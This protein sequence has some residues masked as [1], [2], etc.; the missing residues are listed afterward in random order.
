MGSAGI[1]QILDL[2]FAIP[3]AEAVGAES[4]VSGQNGQVL[5]LVVAVVAAVG[6][7]VAYQRAVTKEEEVRVR[8]EQGAAGVAAEAVDV[9]SVAGC[10]DV[11]GG[12]RAEWKAR[13]RRRVPVAGCSA[14]LVRMP[15]LPRESAWAIS[16]VFRR[17]IN[18][19]VYL[20]APLARIHDIVLVQRR[21][22]ISAW[23]LHRALGC[24]GAL[25]YA[26]AADRR[27]ADGGSLWA[28]ASGGGG[29]GGGGCCS[30]GSFFFGDSALGVSLAVGREEG[31]GVVGRKGLSPFACC[32]RVRRNR[33]PRFKWLCATSFPQGRGG[34]QQQSAAVTPAL[35]LTL[36]LADWQ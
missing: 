28:G 30:V 13:A 36:T 2:A 21:L 11:S 6:A 18:L 9:P 20:S 27:G 8:V 24:S 34:R 23:R 17:A 15:C 1:A 3:A 33:G 29:S 4:L 12:C 14:Y 5:D 26:S 35:A 32:R 22:W 7:V 16:V 31:G 10:G 25:W 19:G